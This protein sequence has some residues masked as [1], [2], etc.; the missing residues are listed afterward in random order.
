MLITLS[1]GLQDAYT[2]MMRD[3]VFAN[4]QTGNI[5]LL[6]ASLFS[7]NWGGALSYLIPLSSFALGI[8]IAAIIREHLKSHEGLFHWRH[9]TLAVE[10]VF[11]TAVAFMPEQLSRI[12]NAMVSFSCALQ[13]EAF[14]KARGHAY[15]STMCIGNLKSC[16]ENLALYITKDDTE[17]I[18]NAGYYALVIVLFA[19]GAGIGAVLSERFGFHAIL[20]SPLLLAASFLLMIGRKE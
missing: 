1:G 13:V 11:L 17:G 9:L 7:G 3:G 4:A 5:V 12:A 8:F 2:F 10:I 15:A 20:I 6:S 18:R 19:L 14:R 16:M